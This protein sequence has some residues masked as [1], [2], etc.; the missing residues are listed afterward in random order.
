MMGWYGSGMGWGAWL[1]MGAFWLALLSLV[2]WLVVRLL[3]SANRAGGGGPR[4]TP[5]EILDRRFAS[6]E[7]DEQTYARQRVALT[8]TRGQG[9]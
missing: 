4:E 9:R 6:G 1:F 7:I 2:V 5:E 8:A 3:P